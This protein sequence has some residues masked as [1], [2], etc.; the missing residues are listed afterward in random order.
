MDDFSIIIILFVIRQKHKHNQCRCSH[1]EVKNTRSSL[2]P[3]SNQDNN[4]NNKA[5][6]LHEIYTW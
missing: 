4:N 5:N 6:I 3:L 1:S 2:D